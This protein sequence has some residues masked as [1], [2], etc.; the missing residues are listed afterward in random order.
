MTI[1][2]TSVPRHLKVMRAITGTEEEPGSGD[3]PRIMAMRDWIA[4]TYPEMSDYCEGYTGDDV[5]W[6][7]LTQA[8]CCAVAGIR[9]PFDPADELKCFLWAQSFANDPGFEHLLEPVLGTIVV[10]TREGGGHVTSFEGWV[11]QG[12]TFK[13]RGGNQSDAINVQTYNV[14]AVIA[15]CWPRGVPKPDE[16]GGGGEPDDPF[17]VPIEDRPMLERGDSGDDVVDLQQMIPR[18][19]GEVDGDFGPATEDAVIRY[20]R[21]RG[22]EADGIVGPMTWQALYDHKPPLPPPEPPPGA[23]TYEQQAAII[24][25]ARESWIADYDW[26][27]RG[28]APAGFTQGMALS[29]AQ[30]LLKLRA[31][32]P[33]VTEMCRARTSSDKDV[34]NEYRDEFNRAGM[35]NEQD[36]AQTLLNLYAFMLGS[37]M[38]ESSGKH[39]EGRDQSVPPGYYGPAS[40]TTE[41]GAFQTSYDASGAS[42]PEFDQ[43]MLEYSNPANEGTCYLQ[44]FAED[45]SCSSSSWECFGSGAGLEFQKLCKNCPAFSV[46]THALTLRNLCNHYGPVIRHEVELKIEAAEM[47]REVQ[48]YVETIGGTS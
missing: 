42:D 40:T 1:D 48:A 23:L 35:S 20:Q 18:F 4:C 26:D 11:Q 12:V 5:A 25:I 10:M 31:G 28:R 39:C 27:E 6:C 30:D 41:A 44:A 36:G 47:F 45:V 34:F 22:L 14:D 19:T 29:F 21:T 9:P 3:N 17:D 32:H 43:L 38:R 33:A 24:K 2:C 46:G 13:A 8:F 16:N 7:G 15:W 37:A